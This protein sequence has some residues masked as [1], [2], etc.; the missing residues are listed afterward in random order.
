M[1]HIDAPELAARY[2]A[3]WTE[4]DAARRRSTLEGLW[5]ADGRHVLQ[6]PQEIRDAAA[7]LGFDHTTLEAHGYDAIET[8]VQRSYDEFVAPGRYTF[9]P[10]GDAVRLTDTVLFTWEMV[11][12][13]TG[14]VAG[15]GREVLVLT[16]DG[17]I[18]TDYMFP[19]L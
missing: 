9:R 3:L 16:P 5:A 15:G 10:A 19:G 12:L 2:I 1:I 14:T 7:A 13:A 11:E 4:P 17:Q 8:R 6:P 18:A